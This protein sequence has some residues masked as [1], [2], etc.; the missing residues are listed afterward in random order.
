MT[1]KMII[2]TLIILIFYLYYQRNKHLALIQTN[3]QELRDLQN[4]VQHYQTLYQ[5]RVAKDLEVN[6]TAKIRN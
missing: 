3:N 2:I 5:K 6:Q 1:E 4:Q